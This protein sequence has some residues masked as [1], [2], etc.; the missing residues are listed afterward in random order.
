[1]NLNEFTDQELNSIGFAISVAMDQITRED[2]EDVLNS[3]MK[4]Q[5]RLE[6]F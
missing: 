4:I 3:L 6:N 1:M 2:E 5:D